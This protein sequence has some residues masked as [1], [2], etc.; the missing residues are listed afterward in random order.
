MKE[1]FQIT[2]DQRNM[3][4]NCRTASGLGPGSGK[5]ITTKQHWDHWNVIDTNLRLQYY[6]KVTAY[7]FDLGREV[8][9]FRKYTVK[10]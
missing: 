3:T 9:A 6:T 5:M 2:R 7:N 10:N 8:P 1:P 4:T